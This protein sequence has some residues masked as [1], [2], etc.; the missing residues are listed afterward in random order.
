MKRFTHGFAAKQIY[1]CGSKD[2]RE[3]HPQNR[4]RRD[5]PDRVNRGELDRP[6]MIAI[7]VLHKVRNRDRYHRKHARRHSEINPKLTASQRK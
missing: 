5:D 4:E 2:D 6:F 3:Q 7:R 1:A